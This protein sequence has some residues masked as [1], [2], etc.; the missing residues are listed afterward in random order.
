MRL[1]DSREPDVWT[2]SLFSGQEPEL[3]PAYHKTGSWLSVGVTD[4]L[5]SC[6]ELFW[7]SC[8]FRI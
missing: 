4:I 3:L 8:D 1:L 7:K 2:G 5:Q 6:A